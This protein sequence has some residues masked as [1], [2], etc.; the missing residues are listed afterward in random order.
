VGEGHHAAWGGDHAEVTALRAAGDRARG[1]T[2]YVTLEPCSTMGKTPPCTDALLAA[3]VSRVVVGCR[4]PFPGHAGRGLDL[5]RAAGLDVEL[6]N[7]PACRALLSRFVE[8]FDSPRPWVV[9]KW[10]QSRDG[11]IAP[12]D[13]A[14]VQLSGAASQARLHEWRAHLDGILVGVGTV[15]ADDPQLTA[16]GPQPPTRAL[17]RVVLDPELRTP[18]GCALV[19]SAGSTATWIY[20]ADDADEQPQAALENAGVAV[21]RLPAGDDWLG[22]VLA[23]LRLSGVR[24]LMVEGGAQTHGSIFGG[25]FVDQVAVLMCPVELGPD[26][27]P[28]L[29]GRDL[30]GLGGADLAATLGLHDVH[31]EHLGDDLLVQGF[32]RPAVRWIPRDSVDPIR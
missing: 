7:H 13:G 20:T 5:L 6:G 21:L 19:Q 17:R 2:L 8:H 25:G 29:P 26:A 27:L 31:L 3:G 18:L 30:S 11:A 12:G 16:R 1:A 23:A 4:D 28:A 9:A 14:R 24:R 10:A 22:S 32:T 15:L